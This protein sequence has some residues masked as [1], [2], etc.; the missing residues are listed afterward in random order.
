[1]EYMEFVMLKKSIYSKLYH[2]REM[3]KKEK[4]KQKE[5]TSSSRSKSLNNL[6]ILT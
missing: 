6:F 4:K 2:F 1:M 5:E 3:S